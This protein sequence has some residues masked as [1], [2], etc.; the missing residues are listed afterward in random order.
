[1]NFSCPEDV[2][3]KISGLMGE[4][5]SS[6]K[7]SSLEFYVRL[8]FE[9]NGA[10]NLI[11]PREFP[12]IWERH[13]LD[14]AQLY[15][16]LKNKNKSIADLGSGAGFPGLVLSI[17][18]IKNITLIESSEKKSH[19]LENVSRETFCGAKVINDR[20]E[21]IKKIKFD[22]I[23]SRAMGKLSILFDFSEPI[24]KKST[25]FFFL[26]GKTYEEEISEAQKKFDFSSELI[27]SITDP[28]SK[29]VFIPH[30][31]VFK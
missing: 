25:E 18:G 11:G 19:F 21:K 7:I 27:Q 15:P 17:L 4:P 16:L 20:V 6:E 12:Q 30:K 23:I 31:P 2:I 26:K 28:E 8:L 10:F 1:M 3:E 9:K 5:I 29:I 13:V 24:S 14:S 22:I